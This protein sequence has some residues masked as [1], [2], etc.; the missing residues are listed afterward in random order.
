MTWRL[1][2]K[3]RIYD[4]QE[5]TVVYFDAYSGDTH[6][7]SDFAGFVMQQFGTQPLTTDELINQISPSIDP[8]EI[9]D[10]EAMVS[11]VLEE[12]VFLDIL[13]RD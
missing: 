10:L 12:L 11:G 4:A 8:Q 6:L 1:H 2:S 13:K 5:S 3:G 9:P 7:L